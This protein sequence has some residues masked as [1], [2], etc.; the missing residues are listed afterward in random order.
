M[1]GLYRRVLTGIMEKQMQYQR[2]HEKERTIV[3][4]QALEMPTPR[5]RVANMGTPVLG[6]LEF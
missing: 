2:E 3:F 5:P 6:R 4:P 1:E